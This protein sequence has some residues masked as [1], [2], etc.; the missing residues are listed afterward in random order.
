MVNH[1]RFLGY[2]KDEDGHLVID[3]DQA[4]VVRM[5]YD[6]FLSGMS[7]KQIKE[8]LEADG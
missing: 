6:Y 1:K 2:T 8:R 3:E 5:I 4:V 7:Q